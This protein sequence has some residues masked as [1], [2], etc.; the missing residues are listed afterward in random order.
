[1]INEEMKAVMDYPDVSFIEDY[2]AARLENDMVNWY[3]EKRKELTGED[4]V[5]GKA[6]DRRILL[7][8]G[9]YFICQGYLYAD[10]AGKMGLLKYSSGDYLENLGALKHIYRKEAAKATV[11]IRFYLKEPRNVATG[12]P[13]GTRL[14]SGDG[15]YFATDEYAE[16]LIGETWTDVG[17]TCLQPGKVGNQYDRGDIK[18]IVNP[19]P[20]IDSAEN[21][22]IPENGTDVEGDES[23]RERI[24]VAPAAYSSA[25][26]KN[27][28]EYF[29]KKFSSE[30]C[31]VMITSPEPGQVLVRYLLNGGRIPGQ[32]SLDALWEYLSSPSIRPVTDNVVVQ[33]PEQA[34]YRIEVKYFINRS[35][36]NRANVI[37]ENVDKYI[38]NYKVWQG[39]KMG[40]DINPS[41]LTG[42]IMAA[43]AKRVEIIEPPF[44]VVPEGTVAFLA[45]ESIVYG[46]LEDD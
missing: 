39:S 11:T 6:D 15:V 13:A 3:K 26:T 18:I 33:A 44:T 45:E 20:F 17:A 8:T 35:D 5:L 29:V 34:D 4:I 46:R 27:A 21:I 19:T 23:L 22:T 37:Q 24:Y 38:E 10:R 2:T 30:I 1:M 25:G 32:E 12:I 40:R 41:E 7:Q 31:D 42:Q 9:A 36:S 43:G 16:I 14:T 28:Y